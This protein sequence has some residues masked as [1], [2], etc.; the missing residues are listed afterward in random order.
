MLT[1]EGENDFD[2]IFKRVEL[3][4]KNSKKKEIKI[5][6]LSDGTVIIANPGSAIRK[7]SK[8]NF[9]ALKRKFIASKKKKLGRK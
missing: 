2:L 7:L 5:K 8:D 4:K 3:V 9:K 6:G 1:R